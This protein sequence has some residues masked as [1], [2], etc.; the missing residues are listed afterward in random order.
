M[1]LA[2]YTIHLNPNKNTELVTLEEAKEL[3]PG[4]NL[5]NQHDK[6]IRIIPI[7][8]AQTNSSTSTNISDPD[9][10]FNFLVPYDFLLQDIW[11][12]KSIQTKGL[13]INNEN[14]LRYQYHHKNDLLKQIADKI[15]QENMFQQQREVQNIYNLTLLNVLLENQLINS[16]QVLEKLQKKYTDREASLKKSIDEFTKTV[17]DYKQKKEKEIKNLNAKLAQS[18]TPHTKNES[19]KKNT[20]SKN[21][22]SVHLVVALLASWL[23]F[24]IYFLK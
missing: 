4:F 19:L 6:L 24:F 16:N 17:D 10:Y 21:M 12:I 8:A 11:N 2:D 14:L 7:F 9:Q 1:D 15:N 20:P 18:N 23:I 22:S 13:N 5:N 3:C